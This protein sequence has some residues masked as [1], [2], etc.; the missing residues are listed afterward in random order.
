M[1]DESLGNIPPLSGSSLIGAELHASRQDLI[2]SISYFKP[3]VIA[4]IGVAFGDF[5]K[6]LIE[7]LKPSRFDAFDIFKLHNVDLIWGKP[8]AQ[9]FSN[10]THLEFYSERLDEYK[11]ILDISIFEGDSSTML[12]QI[13]YHYDLIYIDGDHSYEGVKKDT[14]AA[15]EKLSSNGTL[16]FNDYIIFDH[17]GMSK[18]GIVPVVNELCQTGKWKITNFAFQEQMFCD[19][20]LRRV[21]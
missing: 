2:R 15:I 7:S 5:S 8:S 21:R 13:N 20:A 3:K 12:S 16:I 6:F 17:I 10:R 19:I 11:N 18:Y 1:S 14:M 4:E 9:I